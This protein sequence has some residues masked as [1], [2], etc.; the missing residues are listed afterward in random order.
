[1]LHNSEIK[2]IS[3]AKDYFQELDVDRGA[4]KHELEKAHW[5][6][7]IRIQF[8]HHGAGS[9]AIKVVEEAY[10]TLQDL[11]GEIDTS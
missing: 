2:R 6:C 9:D 4:S 7:L 3:R 8:S 10:V 5:R 11:Q 1:L